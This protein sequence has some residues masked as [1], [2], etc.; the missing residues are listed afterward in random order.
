MF[1]LRSASLVAPV[2]FATFATFAMFATFA[3]IGSMGCAAQGVGQPQTASVA[4]NDASSL[5]QPSPNYR[6][7]AV[8]VSPAS[9]TRTAQ[10]TAVEGGSVGVSPNARLC[11]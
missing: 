7:L 9:A 2:T 1:S 3:A 10:C 4:S 8:S 6:P 11:P 5:Y